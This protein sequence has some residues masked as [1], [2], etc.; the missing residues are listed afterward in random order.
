VPPIRAVPE[1]ENVMPVDAETGCA[2]LSPPL[3]VSVGDPEKLTTMPATPYDVDWSWLIVK[4]EFNVMVI[5]L[6]LTSATSVVLPLLPGYP[7]EGDQLA[8]V[9]QDPLEPPAQV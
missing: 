8:D 4:V 6:E 9:V 5:E 7:V 1:P 3:I 2:M